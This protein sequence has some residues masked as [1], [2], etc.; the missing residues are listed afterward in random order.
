MFLHLSI[1]ALPKQFMHILTFLPEIQL[2][3]Q[4]KTNRQANY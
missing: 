1:I 4:K 3:Y 2:F